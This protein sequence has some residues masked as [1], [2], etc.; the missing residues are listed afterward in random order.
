MEGEVQPGRLLVKR[1]EE[2][3]VAAEREREKEL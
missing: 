2:G 3:A 1:I